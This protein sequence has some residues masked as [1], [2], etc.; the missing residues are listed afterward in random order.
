MMP[1]R[2]LRLTRKQISL[3]AKSTSKRLACLLAQNEEKNK[4][5]SKKELGGIV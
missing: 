4:T 3:I 2:K 1:N 5:F